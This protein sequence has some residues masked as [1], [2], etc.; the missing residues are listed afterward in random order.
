MTLQD[1]GS[2]GELVGGAAVVVSLVYLA[3][4]IRHNTRGLD[5]NAEL[6]RVSFEESIRRE[7][8]GFRSAISSNEDLARIWTRG[9]AGE[10]D[11]NPLESARFELLMANVLAMLRAQFDAQ[12]R[13]LYSPH[14]GAFFDLIARSPGFQEWWQRRDAARLVDDSEFV[15]YIAS[16]HRNRPAVDNPTEPA[17]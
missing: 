2:L 3:L 13:G 7:A 6:M 10:S 1:L 15:A 4:Q 5:Q 17:V 11:L 12:R 8:I 14:R 16:R 9:L